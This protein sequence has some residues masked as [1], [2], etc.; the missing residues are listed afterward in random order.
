MRR[1]IYTAQELLLCG[2][3]RV[4][5]ADMGNP[6]CVGKSLYNCV[7]HDGST[8]A[9]PTAGR[10]GEGRGDRPTRREKNP[11][12]KPADL[13][14]PPSSI[15]SRGGVCWFFL[16]CMCVYFSFRV[17][18]K[19]NTSRSSPRCLLACFLIFP[20]HRCVYFQRKN[21]LPPKKKKPGNNHK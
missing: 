11:G 3:V 13:A 12:H 14:P 15:R 18:Q 2:T 4:R 1:A 7:L 21:P 10:G 9:T 8:S 16:Q 20:G 6:S 17:Q 5:C 19:P